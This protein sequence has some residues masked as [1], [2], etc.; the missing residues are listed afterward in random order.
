MSAKEA[1][2]VLRRVK[3]MGAQVSRLTTIWTDGGFDGAPFMMWVMDVCRWTRAGGA[4]T[5]ANEG[6]CVAQKAMGSG[7]HFR[8]AHGVSPIGQRL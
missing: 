5:G 1:C 6:L 8:L 3:Q 7:T 2:R 4:A